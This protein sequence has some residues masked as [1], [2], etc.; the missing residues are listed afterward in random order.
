[1]EVINKT[2]NIQIAN[3][4]KLANNVFTRLVGLLNKSCLAEDEG[5]LIQSCRSIHSFGMRFNFDAVFLD[6]N[7]K[8]K[9]IIKNMKPWRFSN[10][11]FSADKILELAAGVVDKTKIEINDILEFVE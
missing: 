5:L 1:M 2:K 6:K 9:H 4:I 8:V 11:V 3:N 10:I 7:N